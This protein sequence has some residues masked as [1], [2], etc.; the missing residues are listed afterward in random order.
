VVEYAELVL[1]FDD[2]K[3]IEGAGAVLLFCC[4]GVQFFCCCK[5][6]AFIFYAPVTFFL[7][8]KGFLQIYCVSS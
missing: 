7:P 3:V 4:E 6:V 8:H 5:A 2:A 1:L